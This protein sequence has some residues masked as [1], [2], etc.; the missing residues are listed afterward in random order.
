VLI[1][2]M[3]LL[4]DRRQISDPVGVAL[5]S[6]RSMMPLRRG[7]SS[8]IAPQVR[9]EALTDFIREVYR[10]TDHT[11]SSAFSGSSGRKYRTSFYRASLT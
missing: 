5:K 7:F 8:A 4:N 1:A 9:R 2:S 10:I 6:T 3:R 11:G